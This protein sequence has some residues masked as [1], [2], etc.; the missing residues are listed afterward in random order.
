[1]VRLPVKTLA[2]TAEDETDAR[3]RAFYERAGVHHVDTIDP[4]PGWEPGGPCAIYVR[5]IGTTVE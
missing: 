3:T 1:M 4:D 5:S 2:D